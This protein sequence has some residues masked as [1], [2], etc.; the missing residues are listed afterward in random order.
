[1]S[2][3]VESRLEASFALTE[4]LRRSWGD[5]VFRIAQASAASL[6]FIEDY[7][8]KAWT[9]D[10]ETFETVQATM[11]CLVKNYRDQ[12]TRTE[13]QPTPQGDLDGKSIEERGQMF[14]ALGGLAPLRQKRPIRDAEAAPT[15]DGRANMMK[16]LEDEMD[17]EP[18]NEG[19]RM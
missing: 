2:E 18:D 15:Y 6:S 9:E 3:E 19:P 10:E 4:Y 11:A 17:D 16:Q 14:A 13:G 12:V 5:D 1:M 7:T 8:G